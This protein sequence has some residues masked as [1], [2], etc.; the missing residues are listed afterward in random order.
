MAE[1]GRCRGGIVG[2]LDLIEEHYA[3]LAYDWRTRFHMGIDEV[4]E[5]MGWREAI[6]HART[7]RSDPGSMLAAAM[8]GWEYPF[9]RELAATIDLFDLQ[10]AKTGAKDRKPYQRPFKIDAGS[11]KRR[12]NAAGRTPEQV[13]EILRAHG[14]GLS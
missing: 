12:G 10:Y 4:P 7:L 2:L 9:P 5:R 13:M 1:G 14:H 11:R 6:A 3:A 8:E